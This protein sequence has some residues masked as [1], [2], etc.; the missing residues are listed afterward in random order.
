M[1]QTSSTQMAQTKVCTFRSCGYDIGADFVFARMS[2][3]RSHERKV[4]TFVCANICVDTKSVPCRPNFIVKIENSVC[5]F[6]ILKNIKHF[7]DILIRPKQL[8]YNIIV[9]VNISI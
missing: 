6:I 7:I 9:L 8:Y 1:V 2:D 3:I 5:N 4:Q